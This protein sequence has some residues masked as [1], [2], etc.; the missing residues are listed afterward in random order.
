MLVAPR[1][2]CV[3]RQAG[4]GLPLALFVITVLALLV[5]G[6]AQLQQQTGE[7]V[8]LQVQSQRAFF[9]AESGA[10]VAITQVLHEGQACPAAGASWTLPFGQ[11]ALAGCDAALRCASQSASSG[12]TVYTITSEGQCGTGPDRAARRVEVRVR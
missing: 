12:E 3:R 11:Q 6:M 2:A 10:Q 4:V 7:S 1:M 8:S 5:V 9:A